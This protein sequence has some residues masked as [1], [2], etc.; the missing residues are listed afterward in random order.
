VTAQLSMP[1]SITRH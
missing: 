1:T